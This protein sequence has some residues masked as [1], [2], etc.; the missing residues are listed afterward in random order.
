MIIALY[1][2]Q[3]IPQFSDHFHSPLQNVKTW[4]MANYLKLYQSKTSSIVFSSD[5][6]R[7]KGHPIKLFGVALDTA[8]TWGHVENL[9]SQLYSQIF[10]RGS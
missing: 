3:M 7:E 2:S 4:F 8:L 5:K 9:C 1:F 6:W 10:A